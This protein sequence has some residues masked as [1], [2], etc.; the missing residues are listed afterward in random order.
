MHSTSELMKDDVKKYIIDNPHSSALD[1]AQHFGVNKYTIYNFIRILRDDMYG[2]I[3]SR[4]YVASQHA[5]KIDMVNYMKRLNFQRIS[6]LRGANCCAA[7]IKKKFAKDETFQ[8]SMDKVLKDLCGSPD[9]FRD[10]IDR[11]KKM[12]KA[13]SQTKV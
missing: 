2:V 11:L 7:D 9:T 8:K 5:S 12:K 13:F 6:I 3:Y 10:N 1:V 4:G